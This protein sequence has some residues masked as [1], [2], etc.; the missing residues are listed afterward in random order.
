MKLYF[1]SKCTETIPRP[2]VTPELEVIT[3]PLSNAGMRS[4]F[5][6]L[7]PAGISQ[8]E[9]S[10]LFSEHV[11]CPDASGVPI[12]E[13]ALQ[14]INNHHT[15]V[16]SAKKGS[17]SLKDC[18][19]LLIL[20]FQANFPQ[21]VATDGN[22]SSLARACIHGIEICDED[23]RKIQVKP[24]YMMNPL[25]ASSNISLSPSFEGTASVFITISFSGD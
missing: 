15:G 6:G 10:I 1:K 19:L 5:F 24:V 18:H 12:R 16:R 11:S 7:E 25:P 4:K 8:Q 14:T 9:S 3:L 20:Q 17:R 2:Q 22:V 21:Q 13:N 23:M